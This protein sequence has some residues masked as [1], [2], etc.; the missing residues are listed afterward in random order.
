MDLVRRGCLPPATASSELLLP[1]RA[2]CWTVEA[3]SLTAFIHNSSSVL[4]LSLAHASGNIPWTCGYKLTLHV[5][6]FG[7]LNKQ[8]KQPYV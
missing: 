4:P 5:R 7:S 2:P 6:C 1:A 8:G 3:S